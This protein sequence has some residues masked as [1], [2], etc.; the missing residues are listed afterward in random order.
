MKYR[1]PETGRYEHKADLTRPTPYF[2]DEEQSPEGRSGSKEKKPEVASSLASATKTEDS[3]QFKKASAEA[4]VHTM[5]GDLTRAERRLHF[6]IILASVLVIFLCI[7]III[8][9]YRLG[10]QSEQPR[11]TSLEQAS[12]QSQK[13]AEQ[14]S[15]D[16][17]TCQ[18]DLSKEEVEER[19]MHSKMDKLKSAFEKDRRWHEQDERFWKKYG[20]RL[21]I[22]DPSQ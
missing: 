4:F 19:S 3:K 14:A 20:R 22:L 5:G 2:S 11:I 16:L 17:A 1:D 13:K 10:R 18:I 15:A 21:V 8:T 12:T 9:C 6:G 7:F